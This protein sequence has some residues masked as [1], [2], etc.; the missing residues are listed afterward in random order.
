MEFLPR[1]R[2][3]GPLPIK[4]AELLLFWTAVDSE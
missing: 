4:P 1:R 3:W 2:Q